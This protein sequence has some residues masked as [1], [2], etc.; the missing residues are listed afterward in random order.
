MQSAEPSKSA[1]KNA[2]TDAGKA[3]KKHPDP[4]G[5]ALI[6]Q[7]DQALA[8]KDLSRVLELYAA[9]KTRC[10]SST[11]QAVPKEK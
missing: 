5:L 9:A 11:V 6:E 3:A 4:E 8:A 10:E 7:A 1:V 2:K